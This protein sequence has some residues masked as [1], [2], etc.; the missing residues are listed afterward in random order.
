VYRE[1]YGMG[2][3]LL[4]GGV[5][6]NA[7]LLERA[8]AMLEEKGFTV[9]YPRRFSPGDEAISVGQALYAATQGD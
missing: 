3:V 2:A 1:K 6:L 8:L 4:S 7:A 5:F 9:R